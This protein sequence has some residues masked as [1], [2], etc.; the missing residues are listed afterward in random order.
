MLIPIL[1]TCDFCEHKGIDHEAV[2]PR[3]MICT[4]CD[5]KFDL[6]TNKEVTEEEFEKEVE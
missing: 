2:P 5:C 3:F 6:Y 1:V 4:L